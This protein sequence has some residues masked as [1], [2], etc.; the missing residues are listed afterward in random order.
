[1]SGKRTDL[2]I[3]KLNG[4]LS[5]CGQLHAE[6]VAAVGARGFRALMCLRPDGEGE[7]QTPYADIGAAATIVGLQSVYIPVVPGQMGAEQI[8]AYDAAMTHLPGP[9]LV[10]CRSGARAEALADASTAANC[11]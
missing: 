4:E 2:K 7:D 5:V 9:V 8:A 10:Y 3:R 6:D 1:M 11:R